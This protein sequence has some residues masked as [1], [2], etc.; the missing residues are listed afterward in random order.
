MFEKELRDLA[1]VPRWSI[2]RV[3]RQQSVA[4]HSY[5]V[6]L[7]ADQLA[8]LLNWESD[9]VQLMRYALVHDLDEILSGDIAAPAKRVIKKAAGAG[10]QIVEKWL[11]QQVVRR[12]NDY[13]RLTTGVT[14][15]IKSIVKTADLLEAVVFLADEQFV[16]NKNVTEHKNY[17]YRSLID[18][19]D[20]LPYN[21]RSIGKINLKLQI[22]HAVNNAVSYPSLIVTGDEKIR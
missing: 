15:D 1:F 20:E 5:F 9:R 8:E 18:S 6:A 10:W 19:I 13:T 12:V 17:L 22:E 16:G 11:H 4:E 7:Y 14:D 2:V 3:T 21:A